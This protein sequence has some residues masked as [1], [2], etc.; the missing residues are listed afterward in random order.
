[1]RF[2]NVRNLVLAVAGP[3]DSSAA[4][5]LA[6]QHFGG[7]LRGEPSTEAPAPA[8]PVGPHFELHAHEEAQT[9]FGLAF[10]SPTEEHPDYAA[11]LC[12]RRILSDGLSSR[13]PFE[14][15][16]KRGL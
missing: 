3:I 2:Y 5:D 15:V 11:H 9:G 7:L 14:V 4:R 10:P 13:L 16:E 6:A 1:H 12:L 8:W